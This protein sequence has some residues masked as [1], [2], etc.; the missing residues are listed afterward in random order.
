MIEIS[1]TS[2]VTVTFNSINNYSSTVINVTIPTL[3]KSSVSYCIRVIDVGVA[4]R[5]MP[6]HLKGFNSFELSEISDSNLLDEGGCDDDVDITMVIGTFHDQNEKLL[7]C[8]RYHQPIPKAKKFGIEFFFHAKKDLSIG[9]QFS[10]V[11][12]IPLLFKML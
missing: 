6:P 1:N 3:D 9:R 7:L 11:C 2:F 10:E 12:Y 5:P 4:S 8:F